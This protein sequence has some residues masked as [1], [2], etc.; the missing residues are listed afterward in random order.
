[1]TAF[2]TA[3]VGD[4]GIPLVYRSPIARTQQDASGGECGLHVAGTAAILLLV[5]PGA[6]AT[7]ASRCASSGD[8]ACAIPVGIRRPQRSW[9]RRRGSGNRQSGSIRRT[10]DIGQDALT[11]RTPNWQRQWE[12]IVEKRHAGTD[13]MAAQALDTSS[14]SSPVPEIVLLGHATTRMT[15]ARRPDRELFRTALRDNPP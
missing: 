15:S 4:D 9:R 11:L 1:M 10:Q 12:R 7:I 3:H 14:D 2:R 8:D 6:D 13:E 5:H